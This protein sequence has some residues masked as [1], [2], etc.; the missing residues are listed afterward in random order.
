MLFIYLQLEDWLH[1]GCLLCLSSY[2]SQTPAWSQQALGKLLLTTEW[3]SFHRKGR[4]SFPPPPSVWSFIVQF[5]SATESCPTPWDPMDCSTPDFPIHHQFPELAQTHHH[6]VGDA[7]QPPYPLSSP[8]PPAFSLF[9]RIRVFSNESVLHIRWLKFWSFS[10][11]ISPSNKYS[12]LISFRMDWL[13]LLAV[14]GI[15]K[16]LLQHHSSKASILQ[17]SAFFMVHFS[18]P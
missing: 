16:S 5:S 7:I 10:F 14:Q 3:L 1:D 17:C 9:P 13:N 18:H 8:S 12:R 4:T 15:L 11:I 6:Q 2:D